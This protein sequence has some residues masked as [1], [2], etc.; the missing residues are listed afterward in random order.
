MSSRVV[1]QIYD[2]FL[3]P[4]GINVSQFAMLITIRKHS[5]VTITKLAEE[6]VL[7]RTTCTRNL[8][9]LKEKGLVHLKHEA[10]RRKKAVELTA[11]GHST[12]K[13]AIPYW[14]EAQKFMFSEIGDVESALLLEKLTRML[15][16]LKP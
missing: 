11:L 16:L 6:A 15:S 3:K 13:A 1:S 9:I 4:A 14:K 10:D 5:P 7:E 12:L 8:K 2:K